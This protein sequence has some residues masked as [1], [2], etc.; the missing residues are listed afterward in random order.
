[1]ARTPTPAAAAPAATT[2]TTTEAD[3]G[4]ASSAAAE[5]TDAADAGKQDEADDRERHEAR[6]LIAFDDYRP[7][8][9]ALLTVEEL[10][11]HDGTNVDSTPAAVDY[12]K[13]LIA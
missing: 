8:D 13:S 4:A 2:A 10:D 1:M 3:A 7:N 5:T 6:V 12:A 9:I 11:L